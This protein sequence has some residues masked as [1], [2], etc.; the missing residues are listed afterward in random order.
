MQCGC[1]YVS[2][3]GTYCSHLQGVVSSLTRMLVPRT[4][5]SPGTVPAVMYGGPLCGRRNLLVLLAGTPLLVCCHTC[6]CSA[7][8]NL[9]RQKKPNK[10]DSTEL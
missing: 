1:S 6:L 10:L 5:Q 9:V 3:G 4:C 7:F 2:F 8:L